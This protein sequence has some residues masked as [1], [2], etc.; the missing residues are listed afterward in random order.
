MTLICIEGQMVSGRRNRESELETIFVLLVLEVN[1][2][3]KMQWKKKN[4]LQF[5]PCHVNRYSHLIF[6]IPTSKRFFTWAFTPI[7]FQRVCFTIVDV[8]NNDDMGVNSGQGLKPETF[9][10]KD[11][12]T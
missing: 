5:C 4:N 10:P 8:D 9:T 1:L 11:F 6:V 12:Q 3:S 7:W 2:C